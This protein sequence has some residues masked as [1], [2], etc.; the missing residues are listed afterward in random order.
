MYGFTH[1]GNIC[2]ALEKAAE[3]GDAIRAGRL[4]DEIIL[5]LDTVKIH[6]RKTDGADA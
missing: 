2:L 4:I 1:L 3:K 6:Y 5:Y